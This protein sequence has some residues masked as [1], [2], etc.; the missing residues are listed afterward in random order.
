[1]V[2]NTVPRSVLTCTALLFHIV[3][4]IDGEQSGATHSSVLE[5]LTNEWWWMNCQEN[6]KPFSI[7]EKQPLDVTI[8]SACDSLDLHSL[9]R[10]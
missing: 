2:T 4:R 8:Y 6:Y 9:C 10:L 1:M 7:S 5:V 3:L